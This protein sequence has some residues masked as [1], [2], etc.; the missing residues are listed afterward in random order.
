MC[1]SV[2]GRSGMKSLGLFS[3]KP[4]LNQWV[5]LPC[6]C[7]WWP[8]VARGRVPLHCSYCLHDNK[9]QA[10]VQPGREGAWAGSWSGW[11]HSWS[12]TTAL[13]QVLM[14]IHTSYLLFLS[15][16]VK[17]W[18]A[19]DGFLLCLSGRKPGYSGHILLLD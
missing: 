2:V 5:V 10:G 1:G 18:V 19:L 6:G 13:Q 7:G 4:A 3:I 15:W 9:H 11:G 12:R 17:L 8:L 16:G 14:P